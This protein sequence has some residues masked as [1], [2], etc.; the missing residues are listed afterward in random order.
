MRFEAERG[1]FLAALDRVR[2][3]VERRSTIPILSHVKID[4]RQGRVVLTA[5][6]LDIEAVT[7][8]PAVD[9][10]RGAITVVA[11][12][13]IVSRMAPRSVSNVMR[14]AAAWPF[15]PPV[16]L[17]SSCNLFRRWTSL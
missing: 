17:A 5:T 2:N 1:A 11:S 14:T 4:A 7:S 12:T 10:A 15:W 8:F 6:D 13:S 3:V 16:N 9:L